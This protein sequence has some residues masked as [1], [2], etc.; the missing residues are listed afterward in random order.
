MM[1]HVHPLIWWGVASR[2][3]FVLLLMSR[4]GSGVTRG[5]HRMAPT[6]RGHPRRKSIATLL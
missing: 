6:K 4:E 3:T 1:E 5:S 2:L